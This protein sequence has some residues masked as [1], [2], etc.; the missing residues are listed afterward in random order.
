MV[1]FGGLQLLSSQGKEDMKY[2]LAFFLPILGTLGV[3]WQV[4]LTV[5]AVGFSRLAKQIQEIIGSP[6]GL[7]QSLLR[8]YGPR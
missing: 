2:L 1:S 8:S 4:E 6:L 7:K 3:M 5:E